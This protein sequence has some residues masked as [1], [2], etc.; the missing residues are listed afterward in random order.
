MDHQ[1]E[2]SFSMSYVPRMVIFPGADTWSTITYNM[3]LLQLWLERTLLNSD[4]FPTSDNHPTL[5]QK[6]TPP[7]IWHYFHF[8]LGEPTVYDITSTLTITFT[9]S[10]S[11]TLK[12]TDNTAWLQL[13]LRR[14]NVHSITFTVTITLALTVIPT[15]TMTLTGNY[16][17][18]LLEATSPI[19]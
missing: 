17:T 16:P 10:V 13:W 3:E 15:L 7:I 1:P 14:Y 18:Q 12:T 8:Q 4:N 6:A 19:R 5:I 11:I 2:N 9:Q